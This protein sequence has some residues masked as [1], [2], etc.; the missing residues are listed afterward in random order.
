M[1]KKDWKALTKPEDVQQQI[2]NSVSIGASVQNVQSFVT[3]QGWQCSGMTNDVIYCST[4]T[5]SGLFLV[6]AKWLME[7]YFANGILINIVVR[8]GFT[9]L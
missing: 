4:P 6:S 9:G 8:K 3:Q 7:F 1:K 5:K 2:E